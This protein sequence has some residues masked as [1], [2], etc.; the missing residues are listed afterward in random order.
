MSSSKPIPILACSGTSELVLQLKG[1]YGYLLV[2]A[3]RP[4]TPAL[5]HLSESW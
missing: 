1:S 3:R 2:E 5:R 4:A